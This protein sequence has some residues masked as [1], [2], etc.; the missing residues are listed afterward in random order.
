MKI[1][2]LQQLNYA[3]SQFSQTQKIYFFKS[4]ELLDLEE[5]LKISKLQI[6]ELQKNSRAR[7]KNSKYKSTETQDPAEIN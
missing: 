2:E 5:H 6:Q 7:L 3:K 4:R 1:N